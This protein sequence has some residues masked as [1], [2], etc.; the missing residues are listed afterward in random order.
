MSE[1]ADRERL[2]KRSWAAPG[3]FHD[4]L[5]GVLKLA[6]PIAIGLLAAYLALA[7][8]QKTKEISFILDKN[9]VDVAKERMRVQAARYQGL[10]ARGRPFTISAASAIQA[11]SSDPLVE[12]NGM[13]AGIR[14]DE[15]PATIEAERGRYDLERE[16]VNVVGPILFT[17]ADGY[18]LQTR[19]VAVNLNDRTVTGTGRV[20][21][22]IPLGRFSADS[23]TA[24]LPERHVTLQGRA[25]LHIVQGGLR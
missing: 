16:T 9:K 19:D 13:R 10:D 6:L 11:T 14:L 4:F 1:L 15:G 20:E 12:I 24:S 23:M 7:P 25:R 18:R 21:G 2:V 8:L 22:Q 17:A 5:I 3:G